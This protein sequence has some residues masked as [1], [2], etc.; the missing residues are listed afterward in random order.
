M[1]DKTIL[2]VRIVIAIVTFLV[3][4]GTLIPLFKNWSPSTN[5]LFYFFLLFLSFAMLANGLS[6]LSEILKKGRKYLKI[7][8]GILSLVIFVFILFPQ[9]QDANSVIVLTILIGLSLSSILI[10]VFSLI[11]FTHVFAIMRVYSFVFALFS[12]I[13]SFFISS[14]I[15]RGYNHSE[16]A[17]GYMIYGFIM[18][19]ISIAVN[20]ITV[21]SLKNGIRGNL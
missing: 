5:T 8:T 4:F 7:L 21:S 19:L 6:F 20:L 10:S 18:F 12:G 15:S 16:A 14:Y 11:E 2:R 1:T 9:D 17:I 3:L 13:Y